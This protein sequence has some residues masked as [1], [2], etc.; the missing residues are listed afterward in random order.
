MGASAVLL[1]RRKNPGGTFAVSTSGA[2]SARLVFALALSILLHGLVIA[3]VKGVTVQS[4]GIEYL[5]V[6]LRAA[7]QAVSPELQAPL[8]RFPAT[9][10]EPQVS[11]G[12]EPEKTGPKEESGS[13]ATGKSAEPQR[14]GGF[15]A[16]ADAWAKMELPLRYYDAM[17]VD[18]RAVPLFPVPLHYPKEGSSGQK[19]GRVVLLLLIS[20][21]GAVDRVEVL[22]AD[23]G[24]R[25]FSDAARAAFSMTPFIPAVRNGWAVNSR[26]IVEVDYDS[27]E[28]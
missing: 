10:S 2:G 20:D 1:P 21:T 26:K 23:P 28:E 19:S 7:D 4:A 15:V 3:N 11:A 17:E 18:Q 12:S 5:E 9:D 16:D 8:Q 27:E 24:H 25:A 22:E 6:H 14:S 13:G